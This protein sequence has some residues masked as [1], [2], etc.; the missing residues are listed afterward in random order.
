MPGFAAGMPDLSCAP[1]GNGPRWNSTAETHHQP[2]PQG[3]LSTS[4]EKF[5]FLTGADLTYF[6]VAQT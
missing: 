3:Q 2:P 4:W 1:A 6:L 5:G